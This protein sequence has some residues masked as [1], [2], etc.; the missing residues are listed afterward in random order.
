MLVIDPEK[1]LG[2]DFVFGDTG[3]NFPSRTVK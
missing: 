3:E 2:S 1:Y